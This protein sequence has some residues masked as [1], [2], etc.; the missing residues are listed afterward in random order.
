MNPILGT[1]DTPYDLTFLGTE[2]FKAAP[3]F[4]NNE[5]YLAWLNKLEKNKGYF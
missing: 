2:V 1:L 4:E 3:R 5:P